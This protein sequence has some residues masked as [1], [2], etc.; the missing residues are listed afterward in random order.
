MLFLG[1]GAAAAVGRDDAV[2]EEVGSGS[3][4]CALPRHDES[5]LFFGGTGGRRGVKAMSK[6]E[7]ENEEIEQRWKEKQLKIK[8]LDMSSDEEE[9]E[10]DFSMR[11]I[12]Q[13]GGNGN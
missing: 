1:G 3:E 12:R 11:L 13:R 6:K 4:A 7:R 2:M 8:A 5:N 9:D 10:E